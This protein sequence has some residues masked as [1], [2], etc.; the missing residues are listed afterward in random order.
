MPC[1]HSHVCVAALRPPLPL[2]SAATLLAVFERCDAL[3]RPDR[4]EAV[5]EGMSEAVLALEFNASAED[6]ARTVHAHPTLSE[7]LMEA[8]HGLTGGYIHI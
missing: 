8:A 5:L 2:D 6:L 4:F 1:P 3:R 7:T